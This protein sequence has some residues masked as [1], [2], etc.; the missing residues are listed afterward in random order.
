[1]GATGLLVKDIS[2]AWF[3]VKSLEKAKNLFVDILGL[4]VFENHVP[5]G[6]LRLGVENGQ[7][8]GM[9]EM[10]A[11][12]PE[13][14]LAPEQNAI[15]TFTVKNIERAKKDLEEKGG[16]LLGEIIE[17]SQEVKV[18]LFK[19]ADGNKFQLVEELS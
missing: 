11:G 5:F 18:A 16:H 3:F 6:W 2:L 12:D 4:K 15:A 10:G 13:T 7:R 9:A 14:E 1:M 17:I 19:D 8:I